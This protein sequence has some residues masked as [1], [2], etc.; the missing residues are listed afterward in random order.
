M[1]RPDLAAARAWLA[2]K[3]AMGYMILCGVVFV[4]FRRQLIA[5]FI[6]EDTPASDVAELV[7][8]G[9]L[10]LIATATFQAFDAM[11]TLAGRWHPFLM[12]AVVGGPYGE[13]LRASPRSPAFARTIG[14]N[15]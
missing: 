3:L 2:L 1:K 14:M 7:R 12:M 15:G 8:L 6:Q 4:V 13:V 9:S 10:F 11:A 5:L